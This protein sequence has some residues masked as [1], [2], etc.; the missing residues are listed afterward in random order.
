MWSADTWDRP[1]TRK[2]AAFPLP[3][4]DKYWPSCGKVDD[5]F[6]D[7]NLCCTLKAE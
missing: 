5:A 4:E 1:Y 3:H 6:G 2:E 7:R